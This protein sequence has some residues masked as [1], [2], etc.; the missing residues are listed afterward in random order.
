LGAHQPLATKTV[1]D[2]PALILIHGDFSTGHMTWRRQL[3]RPRG[4]RLVVPDRRGYGSSPP[5]HEPHTVAIDV[6]DILQVADD[7]G[8]DRFDLAG[9]SYGGLVAIAVAAAA[10]A[11][12]RSLVLVEP[13]LLALLPGDP[14]VARLREQTTG[15]W[16]D[17]GSMD[18]DEIA[19][20]FFEIVA[21]AS[22]AATL[23]SSPGWPAIVKETRRAIRG[24]PA[25]RF[26]ADALASI[27]PAMGV[28]VLSGGRSHPG[29]QAISREIARRMPRAA[30]I[31]AP[32]HGHAAHFDEMSF[33]AALAAASE[34]GE[35]KAQY[36]TAACQ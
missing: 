2:G 8:L 10:P 25:D 33:A 16:A 17:A 30:L 29:L 35:E 23:R 14:D 5:L 9:H 22:G 15:I 34:V 12:A 27:D 31:C 3:E 11:R 6:R 13:P 4:R 18:D 36:C 24:Q 20:R 26:P 21:G 28:A 19:A 7:E 1:G 32:E